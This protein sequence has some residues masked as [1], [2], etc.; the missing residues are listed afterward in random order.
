MTALAPTPCTLCGRS[1]TSLMA[2]TRRTLDRGPDPED[3]S[4]SITVILPDVPLCD[5]HTGD[6]LNGDLF[7]GW[8][9]DP[10]CRCYGREGEPSAC[11]A[12]YGQLG[13]KRSG[14]TAK[15]QGTATIT[16]RERE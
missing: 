8:C 14:F 4:F 5:E 12:P 13:K 6:V 1:P 15:N 10:Q 7:L 11:G 3:T 2:P 9:D 16:N